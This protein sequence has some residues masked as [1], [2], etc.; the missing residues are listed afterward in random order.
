MH[1]VEPGSRASRPPKKTHATFA[2][3][4]KLS[5]G[6]TLAAEASQK[7]LSQNSPPVPLVR[8]HSV[9][10]QITV[11]D[12]EFTSQHTRYTLFYRVYDK[13]QGVGFKTVK[14]KN[15]KIFQ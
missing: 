3:Y 10:T 6:D 11:L 12:I 13:C 4:A 2:K 14:F 7:S 5:I 8:G 1:T 15:N 9:L